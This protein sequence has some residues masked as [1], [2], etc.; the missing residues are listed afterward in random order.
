LR[1]SDDGGATF[2]H[3]LG[4]TICRERVEVDQTEYDAVVMADLEGII[5]DACLEKIP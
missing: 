1:R 3:Y 2:H 5:C 4:C